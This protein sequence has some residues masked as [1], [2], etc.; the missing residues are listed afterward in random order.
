MKLKNLKLLF[1]PA[2]LINA[3]L[4]HKNL[5]WFNRLIPDDIYLRILFYIRMGYKLNL[6]Q[7]RTF[8]EKLQW[9]KLYDRNPRYTTLVDKFAVK[10]YVSNIIGEEYIIPTLGVWNSFEDIDFSQLPDQFVLKCTHDSGGLIICRDKNKL[11]INAAKDIITDSLKRNYYLAGRE[12]PY[13][14]VKP[15]IIAEEYIAPRMSNAPCDIPDFKFYCFDGEPVYCQVIRDRRT[16]ETIDFY[17]MNWK[18]QVFV[19]LTEEIKNGSTEVPC[20]QNLEVMKT[21]CRKLSK[22]IPFARIDLY[23]VDGKEYF[24]E[25]TF[26]PASG[27]GKFTPNEYNELLGNLIKNIPPKKTIN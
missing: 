21:I 11:D 6:K 26:Y 1:T 27:F 2:K 5:S 13:K 19:G 7:P 8:N 25:V 16:E 20:P 9:L 22:N 12:W 14:N 10:E 4:L 15:R 3:L 17:D 24:G 23:E 18:H